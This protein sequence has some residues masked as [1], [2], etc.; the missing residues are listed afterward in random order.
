MSISR[1]RMHSRFLLERLKESLAEPGKGQDRLDRIVK[2]IA[3]SMNAEVCSIYL[4]RDGKIL[5]L[6]ATH[7]LKADAVHFTKLKMTP[8]F[9]ILI[10]MNSRQKIMNLILNF[11]TE[12]GFIKHI[13]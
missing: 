10:M 7:G 13:N 6:F 2:L 11:C 9:I 8:Y 3:S 1:K 12:K 4:K 5:E